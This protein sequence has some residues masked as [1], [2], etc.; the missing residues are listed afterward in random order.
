MSLALDRGFDGRDID[1]LHRHHRLEGTP[2]DI[3][4]L[5]HRFG[6]DARGNLPVETPFILAPAALT[7]SAAITDDG[8]PVTVSFRLILGRYLKRK[9]FRLFKYRST[10]QAHARHTADGEVDGQHIA[11]LAPRKIARR[12]MDSA[13]RAVRESLGVKMRCRFGVLVVPKADRV[14]V[15]S[16]APLISEVVAVV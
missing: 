8:V 5:G 16:I 11:L 14:F 7:L 3:A 1:L 15:H 4:A 6:Q 12:A 13:D 2:G 9:G 10:V